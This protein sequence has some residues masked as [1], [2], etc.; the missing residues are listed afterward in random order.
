MAC[1]PSARHSAP[2]IRP[3]D[4]TSLF[5]LG[6]ALA[7]YLGL[8]LAYARAIPRWNEPDE[9][10]HFNYALELAATGHLPVLHDGDFPAQLL[11]DLKREKFPAGR[12][13]AGIRYEA[14]QP[15]FYY[16]LVAL[17]LR[18]LLRAPLEEQVAAARGVSLALGAL[19]VVVA[20][21]LARLALPGDPLAQGLAAGFTALV[22]MRSAIDGAVSNDALA[23]VMTTLVT[24]GAL[25]YLRRGPSR[26]L[27]LALGLALG[28]GVLTKVSVAT[29]ALPVGV[30]VAGR[31]WIERQGAR[32]GVGAARS[33]GRDADAPASVVK[34][35]GRHLSAFLA[36]LLIAGAVCSWWLARNAVVYGR[37]DL[38]GLQRQG[39]VT[40]AQAQLSHFGLPELRYFMVVTFHSFWAQFGWMGVLPPLCIYT[41]FEA[42]TLLP[43]AGLA[44]YAVRQI[45]GALSRQSTPAGKG[46]APSS[47]QP[48]SSSHLAI[49]TPHLL[50]L[51]VLAMVYLTVLGGDLAYNL[52]YVQPQGRYLFPAM[53]AIAVFFA[54]GTRE[55]AP[56]PWRAVTM[57]GMAVVLLG[58]NVVVLTRTVWPYFR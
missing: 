41:A 42:L 28:L 38:F 25:L 6:L 32:G 30:A 4:R 24:L 57:P 27:V 55:L 16:A 7:A 39:E 5:L 45:R 19:G 43:I 47:F 54:L 35:V 52:R 49:P 10:A 23:E 15:P 48:W 36:M 31:W 3:P 13:V 9:P 56:P 17:A 21:L 50:D 58:L 22:P 2:H 40:A 20:W 11:D 51:G 46:G 44:L 12:S 14:H 33:A 18:P 53:G 29:A 1:S 8:G 26:R 34:G 37:G